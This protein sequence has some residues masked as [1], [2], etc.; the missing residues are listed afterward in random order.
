MKP[1]K[2]ENTLIKTVWKLEGYNDIFWTFL[3]SKKI[4]IKSGNAVKNKEFEITSEK[5]SNILILGQNEKYTFP[6]E[7]FTD[8]ITFQ[9]GLVLQKIENIQ[10]GEEDSHPK[11]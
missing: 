5:A 9:E 1:Q 3:P 7:E 10:E 4:L 2:L 8:K 11:H 6:D